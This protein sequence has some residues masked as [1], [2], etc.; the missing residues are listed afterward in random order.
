MFLEVKLYLEIKKYL[1]HTKLISNYLR[2]NYLPDIINYL[3]I[4]I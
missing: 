1:K 3:D 2:R 4:I